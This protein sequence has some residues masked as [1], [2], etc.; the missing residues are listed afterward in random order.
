MGRRSA[1]R[2]RRSD[3]AGGNWSEA[4]T[5][6][7]AD[8]HL[9]ERRGEA[10]ETRRR[11]LTDL[12]ALPEG[13]ERPLADFR[14]GPDPAGRVVGY[15]H[16]AMLFHMLRERIGDAAFDAGLRRFAERYMFH[17][18][19]WDDLAAAFGASA[20]E[21]LEDFF[22]AW[23]TRRAPALSLTQVA[24]RRTE[25]GWK[26]EGCLA[27]SGGD[28]PWPLRVPLAVESDSGVSR[29]MVTLDAREA[30]ISLT[31]E[32]AP[33]ALVVD[34]DFAVLRELEAAPFTLRRLVLDPE[35]RLLALDADSAALAPRLPGR[36]RP[37]EAPP[38]ALEEALEETPLMVVGETQAVAAW[39]AEQGLPEPP[40]DMARRG[41]ARM[42][43]LPGTRLAALSAD[44]H[45]ALAGLAGTL[46]HHQHRSYLVLE[47]GGET[48]EAGTW[49]PGD[50]GLRVELAP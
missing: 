40:R 2:L 38:A 44:D 16:G 27:Q 35:T 9:D 33:R 36:P 14:G 31:L 8:Y 3:R 18:A 45:E 1:G 47:A 13:L 50:D 42:W 19:G 4:L 26:L 25:A 7:L 37:L 11:W 30:E 10:R 23:V 34:P 15:Q 46:R 24:H 17:A 20:G 6:Y 5:T 39:L 49:P 29:H 43:T 41:Q 48:R 12:A 21:P 32:E 22:D 28:A